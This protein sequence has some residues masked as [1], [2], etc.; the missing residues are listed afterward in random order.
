M[1][2]DDRLEAEPPQIAQSPH[3]LHPST[4]GALV[5][6]SHLGLGRGTNGSASP[7]VEVVAGEHLVTTADARSHGR[8]QG[9]IVGAAARL[10][11]HGDETTR[12]P[13]VGGVA[14]RVNAAAL[15]VAGHHGVHYFFGG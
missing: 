4:C 12:A 6:G 11:V 15:G 3:S 8:W 2:K 7:V 10:L 9:S 14:R 5:R 1:E 13:H